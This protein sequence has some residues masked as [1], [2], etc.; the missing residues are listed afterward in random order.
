[1]LALLHSERDMNKCFKN[2]RPKSAI[3]LVCV[4]FDAELPCVLF[5]HCLYCLLSVVDDVEDKI[6]A[7]I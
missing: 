5:T 2:I 7:D 4:S 1:M 6:Y 3:E